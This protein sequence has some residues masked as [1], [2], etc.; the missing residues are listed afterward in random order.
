MLKFAYKS[1]VTS[2]FS[3]ALVAVAGAQ[4]KAPNNVYDS[5][6]KDLPG[7]VVSQPFEANSGYGLKE[8]GDGL[9]ASIG[10]GGFFDKVT[11]VMSSWGCKSGHWT[12]TGGLCVTTPTNANFD[13]PITLNIYTVT[14]S[15]GVPIQGN[16]VVSQTA[17]Q[18]I[19]LPAVI[20]TG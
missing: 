20:D 16:L 12:G 3:L 10:Y 19:R 7:N 17:T 4:P 18:K 1:L 6:P 15:A 13:V 14:D 11:V 9:V 2:I 5:I 8:F